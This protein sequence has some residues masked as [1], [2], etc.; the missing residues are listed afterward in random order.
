L[1]QSAPTRGT[2][3]HAITL[4]LTLEHGKGETVLPSGF[5][6]QLDGDEAKALERAGF[7]LPHPDGGAPAVL[8][9]EPKGDRATTTLRLPLVALPPKAGRH[10]L[11]L[12]AIPIAVAR[13][14]GELITLCTAPHAI[15]IDDPI[16]N[17]PNPKPTGNP[18][19]RRQLEEWTALKHVAI[20]AAVAL[21]V[22]AIV[23]LLVSRWLRRPRPAP[24]A[25]PPRPPWEVA[26]EELFDI[27]HAGLIKAE[28]YA[29]HF[30]RVSDTVRKY[31]GARFG[32]DGLE[33]TTRE[34]MTLLRRVTPA[35]P[36]L[37]EIELFLR[38]ADLVKFARLTP[39]EP[40][41]EQALVLGEMI[42]RRTMPA[43]SP[44]QSASIEPPQVSG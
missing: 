20:A 39:S 6:T 13:A 34:V 31:L 21:V 16:A 7:F 11:V 38:E 19:P 4:E 2:S 30:D 14:S 10:E 37:T 33:S 18:P 40:E 36:V 23:A 44:P 26:I 32:F 5:R 9:T 29:E 41:C 1:R 35:I 17:T 27:R 22:G 42:V 8:K 25:P 12:P 15:T 43:A 28:R 24:P 3:G